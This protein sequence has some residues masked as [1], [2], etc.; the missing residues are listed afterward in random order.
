MPDFPGTYPLA[1]TPLPLHRPTALPPYLA[2]P[3]E[4]TPF[5]VTTLAS[6]M[7]IHVIGQ[8]ASYPSLAQQQQQQQQP[9]LSM[10]A[11]SFLLDNPPPRY[12]YNKHNPSPEASPALWD[13]CTTQTPTTTPPIRSSTGRDFKISTQV[14]WHRRWQMGRTWV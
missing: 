5:C 14:S 10:H 8:L 13:R 7:D 2:V 1:P 12:R 6:D 9:Q 3:A 4:L 11:S